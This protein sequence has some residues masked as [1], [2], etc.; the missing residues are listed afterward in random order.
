MADCDKCMKDEA[1]PS[2]H[3][4]TRRELARVLGCSE[5]VEKI[6]NYK[7]TFCSGDKTVFCQEGN[8][9]TCIKMD[10]EK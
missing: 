6:P 7:G 10:K 8:C 4:T 3:F 2:K 1:C 5:Y 9:N